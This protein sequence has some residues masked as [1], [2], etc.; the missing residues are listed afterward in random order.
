MEPIARP[1]R[2]TALV[3]VGA[4]AF[5]LGAVPVEAN[6]RVRPG[7][8]PS[9]P[10][11]LPG[12]T[13]DVSEAMPTPHGYARSSGT[14]RALTLFI[15]FPDAPAEGSTRERY[16]E[17]LPATTDYFAASSYGRLDYRPVPVHRW[18]RMSKPFAA[19]GIDRGTRWREGSNRGYDLL[20]REIAAAVRGDIDFADYDL[21]N[22]LVAP[23][24]GPP[25]TE[26]VLSVSFAGYPLLPSLRNISFIWSRQT[27]PSAFRVLPHEN[28]HTF[29]LPDLYWTR[30]GKPPLLA[31]HWDVMESD[32]GPTNDFLAWHK[33]KLGWL[34]ADQTVCVTRSGVTEHRITPSAHPNGLKLVALPIAPGQVLTL[35]V[36]TRSHLDQLVCRPG[37]LIARINTRARS[38][39]GPVRV[40]DSRPDSGGCLTRDDPSLHPELT[41]APYTPGDT[42]A[43]HR[44]GIRAQILTATP[45]GTHRVR[46]IRP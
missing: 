3:A 33:W 20:I 41:D 37:V 15:D 19:Y 35:E 7:M 44:T 13:G 43:D 2:R 4:L 16:A 14:V 36:R 11:A 22:I 38:G 8:A 6:E 9:G 28:G 17:F 27:G 1:R 21:A 25:A 32:W 10:C 18:L 31:G 34:A 45:T 23:N 29:G 12:Y 46:I 30:K 5:S 40:S 42:Y 39:Q 26:S 24:A